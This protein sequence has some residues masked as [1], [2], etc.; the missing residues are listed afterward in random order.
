MNSS[1]RAD[2]LAGRRIIAAR[3]NAEGIERAYTLIG[4]HVQKYEAAGLFPKGSSLFYFGASEIAGNAGLSR[5]G[6]FL[7]TYTY[8]I[9]REFYKNKFGA[10]PSDALLQSVS[11]QSRSNVAN[12]FIDSANSGSLSWDPI[13]DIVRDTNL[14]S[15]LNLDKHQWPGLLM[16]YGF[17]IDPFSSQ[18]VTNTVQLQDWID[19]SVSAYQKALATF[20][21]HPRNGDDV[22][23]ILAALSSTLQAAKSGQ[24]PAQYLSL[25]DQYFDR[26][27]ESTSSFISS[28]GFGLIGDLAKTL[29]EGVYNELY[30]YKSGRVLQKS[31]AEFVPTNN[32]LS[33][34]VLFVHTLGRRADGSAFRMQVAYEAGDT[35]AEAQ[36]IIVTAP[37]VQPILIDGMPLSRTPSVR[38][39]GLAKIYASDAALVTAIEMEKGRRSSAYSTAG[40]IGSIIGSR[41]GEYLFGNDPLLQVT[42]QPVL[43]T[44]T[45]N[46]AQAIQAGG[47]SRP[48]FVRQ[49]DGSSALASGVGS[50]IRSEFLNGMATAAVGTVSSLLSLELG[51]AIGVKGFGGELLTTSVSSVTSHVAGNV[52]A[53]VDNVFAGL[54]EGALFSNPVTPGVAAPG[55]LPSAVMSFLGAKLG[56]LIISP[57]TKEGALFASLGSAVGSLAGSAITL[58]IGKALGLVGAKGLATF[59]NFIAPGVGALV[60]FLAG[61]ILGK[62]FFGSPPKP[63]AAAEVSLNLGTGFWDM[64]AVYAKHGANKDV[65]TSMALSARDAINGVIATVGGREDVV[66][67][68]N[69]VAEKHK[70]RWDVAQG[71]YEMQELVGSTFVKRY[72]GKD[73]SAAIDIG[74]LLG[75]RDTLIVGGDLFMKRA[76]LNYLPAGVLPTAEKDIIT[77][78]GNMQIAEDFG[79]YMRDPEPINRLMAANPNSA[80]TAAWAITL[81]RAE[82]LG[83]NRFQKS[84]FYG[85]MAGFLNSVVS[86]GA[87]P[88][89]EDFTITMGSGLTLLNIAGADVFKMMPARSNQSTIANTGESGSYDAGRR[90]TMS[91]A[92]INDVGWNYSTTITS[93]YTEFYQAPTTAGVV[94][95]G[96]GGDDIMVGSI[97]GDS[98][99]GDAGF[100]WLDGWAGNDKLFGGANNDVLI[101]QAG[102]DNLD[103]G[104]GDDYL[105]GGEGDDRTAGLWD[106]LDGGLYGGNGNDTL[107][108]GAGID[109]LIG[110]NGDDIIIVDDDAAQGLTYDY[111]DGGPGSDTISYERFSTAVYFDINSGRNTLWHP[112]VRSAGG[113]HFVWIENVTGTVHSDH[114]LGD[115]YANV[116]KGL[117]GNDSLWGRE[118]DD[119]LEGGLGADNLWGGF[120]I[121]TASYASSS[122]GVSVSLE[123]AD[124]K[125]DAAYYL[126]TYPDVAAAG[127]D[128]QAHFNVAG[129]WERRNPN[130]Y[131]NTG[132]YL[133]TYT[134]VAAAGINAFDHYRNQGVHE[135][136]RPL[137]APGGG[138][139]AFGGDAT[140]DSLFSIENLSGSRFADVLTGNSGNNQLR[141]NGGDDVLVAS[142]GNDWLQGGD[143]F[144]TIDFAAAPNAVVFSAPMSWSVSGWGTGTHDNTVEKLV[145]S[146]HADH[147]RTGAGDHELEGGAGNDQLYGGD[148]NDTYVFAPGH[149]F[150]GVTDTSS[151]NNVLR[152]DNM[153]WRDLRFNGYQAWGGTSLTVT[154]MGGASSVTV[155]NQFPSRNTDGTVKRTN[156]STGSIIKGIDLG[157]AGLVEIGDLD[158]MPTQGTDANNTLY[159]L[160]N[161]DD[162]LFAYG[163][164]DFIYASGNQTEVETRGNV[165]YAG[166]GNDFLWSST[167][168]DQYIFERGNG[169]DT[170]V[171]AGGLDTII[172]GPSI[173]AEDVS[174]AVVP[175]GTDGKANLEILVRN[176]GDPTGAISDKIVVVNGAHTT[177]MENLGTWKPLNTIEFV[178]VGGQ[179]IDLRKLSINW[180]TF[181][182]WSMP[183]GGGA[184]PPLVLDLDGDGVEL[185]SVHGS[186]LAAVASDGIVY[187]T[188]WVG[189]DDGILALDRNGDGTINRQSE[190]SFTQDAPGAKT[191]LEGLVAYDSNGDGKLSAEDARWGEFRVWRDLNQDGQSKRK[192]LMT[193]AEAGVKSISLSG[194]STGQSPGSVDESAIVATTTVEWVDAGR[195]GDAYDV[196]LAL[197]AVRTDGGD[198]ALL[199]SVRKAEGR[200]AAASSDNLYGHQALTKD[201]SNA[202]HARRNNLS[203]RS[204]ELI[205]G[206]IE[207]ILADRSTRVENGVWITDLEQKRR[208]MASGME[209]EAFLPNVDSRGAASAGSE[210]FERDAWTLAGSQDARA[211]AASEAAKVVQA[212]GT[213]GPEL[214]RPTNEAAFENAASVYWKE[215]EQAQLAESR[216]NA[217]VAEL[218]TPGFEAAWKGD[219]LFRRLPATKADAG[220]IE[221]SEVSGRV[222][223]IEKQS[224]ST[225]ETVDREV[226]QSPQANLSGP[227]GATGP[228]GL[229]GSQ[230]QAA[231]VSPNAAAISNMIRQKTEEDSAGVSAQ[232]IQVA[233]SLLI[234]AMAGFGTSSRMMSLTDRTSSGDL[235]AEPWLSV[236]ALPSVDRLARIS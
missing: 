25:F 131:F 123:T 9:L 154:T 140:G 15:A 209:E 116:L 127:V 36:E 219:D 17:G 115:E 202:L 6:A 16:A 8:N 99:Y 1:I 89:Y 165:V 97:S 4:F 230:R 192:E 92:D 32:T 86:T 204:D 58:A 78:L 152:F 205:F 161:K 104:D 57:V 232:Q 82:E 63:W 208:R 31:T 164:T 181:Y 135:N 236:S 76:I 163:G 201:Q 66:G 172:M 54:G 183:P 79:R 169:I 213:L 68:A 150:D 90:L 112:E 13:T 180:S 19:R 69:P 44:L 29:F 149:G 91:I 113:D 133:D 211:R 170:L 178:R 145:G 182:D 40:E 105:A 231:L 71:D 162:L 146:I 64:G 72:D 33:G 106:R 128:P 10:E 60:G 177:F 185:R 148:G 14:Q 167:G 132:Y 200:T 88:R 218:R 38:L 101:G 171:D 227:D 221:G 21:I 195:A 20:E 108:G 26:L 50:D 80:F 85:G 234:Q 197:S 220:S 73:A 96:L 129:W 39:D 222:L 215:F 144:D 28:L 199:D 136:R 51:R 111:F 157:G 77:L 23:L 102:A 198:A 45:Q 203:L 93:N 62:V 207:D 174:F 166:D 179:I 138:T 153:N 217:Q 189:P 194:R 118:G 155:Y 30:E 210:R 160:R 229:G 124:V 142:G 34:S 94:V 109:Y 48:V 143:G 175:V 130:P 22:G 81:L 67:V 55:A 12:R 235:R 100:D 120:G 75:I 159:G 190:I 173:S 212:V 7:K 103:G 147:L 125:F 2:E 114:L 139:S 193:L 233:N 206:R 65:V 37:R 228:Q 196:V 158:F 83:L 49:S 107:V 56:S 188:G 121:D 176:P 226:L 43:A 52:L 11:D 18:M 87:P 84:D 74:V 47:F 5:G 46:I 137:A 168:D 122:S 35:G 119:T 151:G 184:I 24:V 117:S 110:E 3:I 70:Y 224:A 186:R 27:R 41:L 191:D 42:V 214:T 223:G 156:G 216:R 98:I 95:S 59:G 126:R 225:P 187:R 53:R 61:A 134:D 141:G